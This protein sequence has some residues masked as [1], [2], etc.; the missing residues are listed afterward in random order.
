M[1]GGNLTSRQHDSQNP[2]GGRKLARHDWCLNCQNKAVNFA[3]SHSQLVE[4][5]RAQQCKRA[6][7]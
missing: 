3:I 1:G 5:S 4:S 2:V 6:I 7:S